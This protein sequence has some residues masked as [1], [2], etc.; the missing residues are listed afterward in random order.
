M[1]LIIAGFYAI[2]LNKVQSLLGEI[3][4][5]FSQ[6]VNGFR[7]YLLLFSI[8]IFVLFYFIFLYLFQKTVTPFLKLTPILKEIAS[9]N[10]KT[11]IDFPKNSILEEQ[12][13][14]LNQIQSN[15]L[16]FINSTKEAVEIVTIA[17]NEMKQSS[18]EMSSLSIKVTQAISQ[19][20]EGAGQ[21]A[22]SNENGSMRINSIVD[23]I[24]CIAQDM[25]A[26]EQ[27]AEAAFDSMDIV[28]NKVRYQ[29][30]KMEE[31]V[32]I[33]GKVGE[34][35]TDLLD[36][37]QKIDNI[38]QVMNNIAKQTN[39]LALNAAIEAARAGAQGKG[40]AVVSNEIRDLAEQSGESNKQITEII[41]EVQRSVENTVKQIE[42]SDLLAAKQAKALSQTVQA[43]D[44]ISDK[45]ESITTK[46]KAVSD[47]TD[48]LTK[49]AKET[50]DMITTIASISQE[51]AAS[52]Q[53]ASATMEEQNMLIQI[54]AECSI[55]LSSIAE[56]LKGNVEKYN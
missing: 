28:K 31:S 22:E 46:V 24:V 26:S 29:E 52:T 13:S 47:A 50:E 17:S 23:L 3:P 6:K 39:L 4:D 21:Q 42:K 35:I 15:I 14:Y 51:T 41:S 20:A 53:E 44:E 5:D 40:F 16:D 49:D 38:L 9:G 1:F 55:E 11:T 25:K 10:Y 33:S 18:S 54:I 2:T 12:G 27:L 36:K 7:I 30:E 37:S 56:S 43:I 34:A 48:S 19:L 32:Q 8:L 45:F